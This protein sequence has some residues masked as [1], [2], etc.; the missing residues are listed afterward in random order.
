[1]IIEFDSDDEYEDF[2]RYATSTERPEGEE[3]ERLR[4]NMRNH[5]RAREL[6]EVKHKKD[7]EINYESSPKINNT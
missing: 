5:I 1:M 2:I 4:D 7:S 3:W 6:N